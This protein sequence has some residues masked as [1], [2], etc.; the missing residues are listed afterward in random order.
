MRRV[1]WGAG[2]FLAS[3]AAGYLLMVWAS[4]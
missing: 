2:M 1:A 3:I 4:R